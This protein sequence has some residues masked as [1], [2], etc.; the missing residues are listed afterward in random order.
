MTDHHGEFV[1]YDAMTSDTEAAK[2]FY[3]G[4]IGWDAK[5]AGMPDHPY[6]LLSAGTTIAAGLM[7]IPEQARAMDVRPCWMG[8]IGVD[9]VDDHAARVTAAGGTIHKQPEDIPGVGRFAVAADPHGAGFLLFKATGTEARPPVAP[10]LQGHAG[11][12]ELHAGDLETAFAFY[13]GLFGWTKA[14]SIDMG[15]M[16]IYRIFAAG[17]APCGGMMTRMAETPAPFWLYYF[18]VD[19][20]GAAMA[21]VKHG[22][23][24]IVNGPMQVP[25]GNWIAQCLDPRGA[26]FEMVAAK[27]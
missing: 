23:G 14:R 12:H 18:N 26:M 20:A 7:P 10:G 11:W 22:G 27:Q 3:R 19:S 2:A 21:R 1:W 5:D 8:Y 4:A 17:G 6:I 16:G 25:G 13:A 24:Q 9:D 15:A